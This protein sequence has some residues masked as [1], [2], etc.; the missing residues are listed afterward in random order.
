VFIRTA[1]TDTLY[2]STKQL[3]CVQCIVRD[4]EVLAT[5]VGQKYNK[6]KDQL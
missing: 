3:K 4:G 2:I 1:K 5:E 6:L